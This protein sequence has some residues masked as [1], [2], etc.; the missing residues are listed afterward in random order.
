MIGDDEATCEHFA[1]L[2]T[3]AHPMGYQQ[4]VVQPAKRA[5]DCNGNRAEPGYDFKCA[6]LAEI[7]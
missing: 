6:S 3:A 2:L 4:V 1:G 5:V 7:R